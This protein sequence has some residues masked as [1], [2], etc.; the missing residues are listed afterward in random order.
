MSIYSSWYVHRFAIDLVNRFVLA[1]V[2]DFAHYEAY[3]LQ[4]D[5]VHP[6]CARPDC[7]QLPV[8]NAEAMTVEHGA[9]VHEV[10]VLHLQVNAHRFILAEQAHVEQIEKRDRMG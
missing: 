9:T 7:Q 2:Q 5:G 4:L 8:K 6:L 1:R 3:D 10:A